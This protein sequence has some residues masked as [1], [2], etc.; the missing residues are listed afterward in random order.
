MKHR[1][2]MVSCVRE[3]QP[4]NTPCSRDDTRL[5]SHVMTTVASTPKFI[6]DFVIWQMNKYQIFQHQVGYFIIF[7]NTKTRNR[8]MLSSGC[9]IDPHL[10]ELFVP[11]RAP[12]EM[13]GRTTDTFRARPLFWPIYT[14]FSSDANTFLIRA[15]LPTFPAWQRIHSTNLNNTQISHLL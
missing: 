12:S 1:F 11:S 7:I 6:P 5:L 10:L 13:N 9:W 8:G 2:Q 14:M 3:A 4:S 15:T